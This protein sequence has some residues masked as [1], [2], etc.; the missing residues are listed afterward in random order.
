MDSSAQPTVGAAKRRRERRLRSMA[1]AAATH[2]SAQP[3]R[4]GSHWARDSPSHHGGKGKRVNS[5]GK[6]HKNSS[7]FRQAYLESDKHD[8]ITGAGAF[9]VSVPS[10][11][12]SA[13]F[14]LDG[15]F[16]WEALICCRE[17]KKCTLRL[18]SESPHI[19]CR[20][21]RWKVIFYIR[22]LGAPGPVLLEADVHEDLGLVVDRVDRSVFLSH[23]KLEDTVERLP[24]RH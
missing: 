8:W 14:D 18:V 11:Q 13:C 22:V 20:T 17:F 2:H 3:R 10:L 4:Q 1:L 6:G 21:C 9:A 24:T 23:L 15:Q 16:T 12:N 19:P 5:C 7:P